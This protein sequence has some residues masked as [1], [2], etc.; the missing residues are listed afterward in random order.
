MIF[1]IK[2]KHIIKRASL[3]LF[4]SYKIQART[5]QKD[6][7]ISVSMVR[8]NNDSDYSDAVREFCEE[9]AEEN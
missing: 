6:G 9:D 3:R 5:E 7:I 1:N 8:Y 4:A 2:K